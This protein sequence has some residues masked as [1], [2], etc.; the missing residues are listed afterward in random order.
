MESK[1]YTFKTIKDITE[2]ITKDN[3]DNFLVDFKEWLSVAIEFNKI[4]EF[5]GLVKLDISQLKW[6][7]DNKHDKVIHIHTKDNSVAVDINLKEKK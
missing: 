7:D 1:I 4:K 5:K 3:I 2:A 6:T